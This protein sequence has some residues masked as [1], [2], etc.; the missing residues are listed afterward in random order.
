MASH[1]QV[2]LRALVPTEKEIVDTLKN[3]LK[4]Q[5]IILMNRR[6]AFFRRLSLNEPEIFIGRYNYDSNMECVA[7]ATMSCKF[8]SRKSEK[9]AMNN[10]SVYFL[11]DH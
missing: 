5:E 1:W 4:G 2:H 9:K 6:I 8:R 3:D 10:K 11:W 7:M